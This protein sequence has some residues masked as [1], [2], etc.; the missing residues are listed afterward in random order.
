MCVSE[1]WTVIE[2]GAPATER[3]P[4]PLAGLSAGKYTTNWCVWA[5]CSQFSQLSS[6]L[7]VDDSSCVF[8]EPVRE[9]RWLGQPRVDDEWSGLSEAKNAFG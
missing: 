4:V 3:N 5:R 6:G 9:L 8:A 2:A 1:S 7:Q